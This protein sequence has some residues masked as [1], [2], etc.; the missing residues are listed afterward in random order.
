MLTNT[1]TGESIKNKKSTYS[2]L[3]L[4]RFVKASVP[5]FCLRNCFR[6]LQTC[7]IFFGARRFWLVTSGG[8]LKARFWYSLNGFPVPALHHEEEMVLTEYKGFVSW[9]SYAENPRQHL[10]Y[11]QIG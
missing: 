4:T 3:I 8:A 1:R 7:A 6:E 2:V 5:V 11:P 9:N 10:H